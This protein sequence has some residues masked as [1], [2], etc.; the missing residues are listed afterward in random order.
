MPILLFLENESTKI[1]NELI[2]FNYNKGKRAKELS[3]MFDIKLRTIYNLIRRAEKENRLH[4][5]NSID[6]PLKLTKP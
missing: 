6:I 1:N 4:H 3:E 2:Y 5:N